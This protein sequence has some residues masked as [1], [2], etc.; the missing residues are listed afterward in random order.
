MVTLTDVSLAQDDDFP[1]RRPSALANVRFSISVGGFAPL[2]NLA[3]ASDSSYG[4]ALSIGVQWGRP[5]TTR[6]FTGGLFYEAAGLSHNIPSP[7]S[8]FYPDRT[9]EAFTIEGGGLDGMF[10]LSAG[11]SARLYIG[12][13]VGI[14]QVK[15]KIVISDHGLPGVF[16]NDELESTFR[17]NP[18]FRGLVGLEIGRGFFAEGRY[19]DAGTME[20][21]QFRGFS[22]SLGYR[23]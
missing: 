5:K 6:P 20:S 4:G 17:V 10:Y 2:G 11:K 23:Y 19:P 16:S 1:F 15:R 22:V 14:F 9:A 21:V 3:S 18:G 8:L 13:G 12:G 7:N